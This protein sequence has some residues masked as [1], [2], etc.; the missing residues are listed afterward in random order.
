MSCLHEKS[1]P[2]FPEL[3]G[4]LRGWRNAYCDSDD[5]WSDCARHRLSVSGKPVPIALL[6]NGKV[7]DVL[8]VVS[9]FQP[10]ETVDA[11]A[12][13]QPA[14]A[15]RSVTTEHPDEPMTYT[16]PPTSFWARVRRIF[17]GK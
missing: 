3:R 5:G 8:Q 17:G 15:A 11:G 12:T 4:S 16:S 9:A 10:A 1:C 13:R 7:I 2:L 6:P 14:M